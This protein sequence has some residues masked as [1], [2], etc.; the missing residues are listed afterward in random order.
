[1]ANGCAPDGAVQDQINDTLR[2]AVSAAR[3]RMPAGPSD[4]ECDE[5][6]EPIPAR[7]H[8]ALP[9][10]RTCVACQADRDRASAVA[11]SGIKRRGSRTASCASDGLDPGYGGRRA[12]AL[13][14]PDQRHTCAVSAS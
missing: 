12:S 9:G 7:R 14:R 6:G 3:D 13:M 5:C 4:K 10:M 2:D 11:F 8:V 1:M